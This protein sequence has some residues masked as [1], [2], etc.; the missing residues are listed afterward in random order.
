MINNIYFKENIR[1]DLEN[2]YKVRLPKIN[3]IKEGKLIDKII[4][5]LKEIFDLFSTNGK[6]LKNTH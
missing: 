2:K 6:S 1:I 4:K 5:I 3:L